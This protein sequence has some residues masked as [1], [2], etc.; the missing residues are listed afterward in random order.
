MLKC[1]INLKHGKVWVKAG[2]DGYDISL[3]TMALIR[4]VFNGIRKQNPAAGTAFKKSIISGVLD[5]NSP[6]WKEE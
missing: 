4:N 2:G 1:N 5:P 6:V 3:E